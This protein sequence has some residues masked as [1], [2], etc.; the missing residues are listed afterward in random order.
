[1]ALPSVPEMVQAICRVRTQA[2]EVRA[3]ERY[4]RQIDEWNARRT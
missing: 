1:M 4:V 2:L 3:F